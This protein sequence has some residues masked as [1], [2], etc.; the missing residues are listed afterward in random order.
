[1]CARGRGRWTAL[2]STAAAPHTEQQPELPDHFIDSCIALAVVCATK[3]GILMV[4]DAAVCASAS[5]SVARASASNSVARRFFAFSGL[6]KTALMRFC[7]QLC[8]TR[9]C[10]QLCCTTLLR[11][12]WP[13]Q[14][15]VNALLPATLLHALLPAA[16]LHDASSHFLA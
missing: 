5:N 10:Q 1:M 9:F 14:N 2:S 12:F 15:S 6:N 11:I 13:E 3:I 4:K 8:C 7:Q 16:L